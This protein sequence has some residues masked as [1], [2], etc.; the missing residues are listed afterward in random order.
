MSL[1]HLS[2]RLRCWFLQQPVLI[3]LYLKECSFSSVRRISSLSNCSLKLFPSS[4][5]QRYSG[6]CYFKKNCSV[7]GLGFTWILVS[8][9]FTYMNQN[10]KLA[11]QC[12]SCTEQDVAVD[13]SDTSD[14]S[15][16]SRMHEFSSVKQVE[17]VKVLETFESKKFSC[18]V[19]EKE[20]I[21]GKSCVLQNGDVF[22]KACVNISK[23]RKRLPPCAIEKIRENHE[24]FRKVENVN[25]FSICG[26]SLILHPRNPMVP[27]VHMNYRYIE[28]DDLND[29][30]KVWWFGG[31]SDLS[32]SYLFEE[33]AVYF[34]RTYKTICDH[35]DKEYYPK[36]KKWCDRYFFIKHRKEC[37]GIGGI[38]FDDLNDKDPEEIFS[39]VKD[40]LNAF[41]SS[42]IPIVLR[43]KDMNFTSDE[44]LFQQIR[45]GRYVEFNLLYD[46]GTAFGL[47]VPE[48][49]IESILA[50][51]PLTSSW[52]YQ[53]DLKDPRE[54]HFTEV[55]KNPVEWV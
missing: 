53:Y 27:S 50:S 8:G 35:Y 4:K 12:Q 52:I 26:I 47:Y 25:I 54:K 37:R 15:I 5:Y 48:S 7:W 21:V 39:F 28:A 36:F 40:C 17:I 34:H 49:R 22:E 10:N 42:Y 18:D 38:F 55:L 32:P 2:I 23:V 11:I 45:C 20:G 3:P 14:E 33:D 29:S 51:L 31:G 16:F 1:E 43:R 41:L 6:K 30:S 46:R 44:K 9:V 24:C 13:E 19:W